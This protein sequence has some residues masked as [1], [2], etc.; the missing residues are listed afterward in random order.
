MQVETDTV[1]VCGIERHIFRCSACPQSAQRL[2]FN[3]ARMSS[4]HL[5]DA[6]AARPEPPAIKLQAAHVAPPSADGRER[7]RSSAADRRRSRSES[8]RI[9]FRSGCRRSRR[10]T[11]TPI[12]L[13]TKSAAA[14]SPTWTN[15]IEKLRRRQIV[16]ERPQRPEPPVRPAHSTACGTICAG[17]RRWAHSGV[18]DAPRAARVLSVPSPRLSYALRLSGTLPPLSASLV[19]TCRCSQRFISAEPSRA[20]E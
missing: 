20:P 9:G 1:A 15:A 16:L 17:M 18:A 5:P 12:A 14:K 10:Q 4:I 6:A 19:M 2:M 8:R 11:S 13:R 3:R 7:S